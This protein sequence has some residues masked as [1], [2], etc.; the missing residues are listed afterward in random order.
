MTAVLLCIINSSNLMKFYL[1]SYRNY[2]N[3]TAINIAKIDEKIPSFYS[4]NE[5]RLLLILK[6]KIKTCIARMNIY[7]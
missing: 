3:Y 1:R 7:I 4:N 2:N 5:N 6:C